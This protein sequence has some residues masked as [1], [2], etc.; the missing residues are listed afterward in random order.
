[1]ELIS[2]DKAIKYIHED[3]DS[4]GWEFVAYVVEKMLMDIPIVEER[5]EGEWTN[6][7]V[8]TIRCSNCKSQFHELE[9]MNFCPNCGAK[10]KK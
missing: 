5:K 7:G 6:T 10:M 9:A 4:H 3:F 1:M 8:L 2:R